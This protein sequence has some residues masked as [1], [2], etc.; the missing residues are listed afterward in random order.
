MRRRGRAV[1]LA[2]TAAACALAWARSVAAQVGQWTADDESMYGAR[3]RP[4]QASTEPEPPN[5]EPPAPRFGAPGEVVVT[6]ASTAGVSWLQYDNSNATSLSGGFSPGIDVFVA[7]NVSVGADLDLWF[8]DN[9]G[10]GADGSLV[11]TTTRTLTGGP[12]VG[13]AIPLGDSFTLYPRLTLGHESV[14]LEVKLVSGTSTSTTASPLGYPS[15]TYSG[16]WLNLYLPLLF[17]PRPH[18][19]VGAGPFGFVEFGSPDG[20]PNVGGQRASVGASLLLGGWWGG[21]PDDADVARAGTPPE[22]I[23]PHRFGARGQLVLSGDIGASAMYTSY[24]GVAS[25]YKSATFAPACDYF[26]FDHVSLGMAIPVTASGS[27]GIDPTSQAPVTSSV[28]AGG[29]AVRFGVDLPLGRWVSLYPR[30]SLSAGVDA[31]DEESKTSTNKYTAEY[32]TVGVYAPLLVH[33][34]SHLFVGF[35]PSGVRDVARSIQNTTYSNP[36][37]R[38]GASLV[39]GGWID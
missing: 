20:G 33:P 17:H 39:V 10:Y 31:F 14:H 5:W 3:Q 16:P 1:A 32:A 29:V 11:E 8:S 4:Q 12:R 2:F 38:V 37:T 34:T 21:T 18:F 28:T 35:G 27:Q 36:G 19:F 23:P 7:R 26:L 24:A 9:K 30:V 6:A 22:T 25:S 15:T 13:L